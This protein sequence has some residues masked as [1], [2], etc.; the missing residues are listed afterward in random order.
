M[1]WP[2]FEIRRGTRTVAA[3]GASTAAGAGADRQAELLSIAI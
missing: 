2:S 1:L 3:G